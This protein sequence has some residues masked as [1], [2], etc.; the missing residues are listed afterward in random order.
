MLQDRREKELAA[1]SAAI[2]QL[3][4]L[5]DKTSLKEGPLTAS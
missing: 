5:P 2:P 1:A 3:S 4:Q